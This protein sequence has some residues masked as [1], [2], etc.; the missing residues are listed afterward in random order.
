MKTFK[1]EGLKYKISDDITDEQVTLEVSEDTDVNKVDKKSQ[2]YKDFTEL[3]GNG[4]EQ[5]GKDVKDEFIKSLNYI[6]S[7]DTKVS[8][9]LDDKLKMEE[10]TS[11]IEAEPVSSTPQYGDDMVENMWTAV[12]SDDK[13]FVKN[14]YNKQLI[15]PGTRYSGLGQTQSLIMGALRNNNFEMAD[16]LKSFGETILKSEVDEY[17]DI[18]TKRTYED[19]TTKSALDEDV[20]ADTTDLDEAFYEKICRA[21]VNTMNLEWVTT[22][23]ENNNSV[24][25][26]YF[27]D[28]ETA[29]Q[30]DFGNK[31]TPENFKDVAYDGYSQDEIDNLVSTLTGESEWY[32]YDTWE[33]F[34]EDYIKDE[35]AYDI[36][37]IGLY[38]PGGYDFYVSKEDLEKLGF[39]LSEFL[40][41]DLNSPDVS[42]DDWVGSKAFW[43]DVFDNYG[44][45]SWTDVNNR[46]TKSDL[47]N[48][49]Q[50]YIQNPKDSY[51]MEYANLTERSTKRAERKMC[52]N[53]LKCEGLTG[54]EKAIAGI[55]GIEDNLNKLT[56]DLMAI[57]YVTKVEYDLYGYYD[58][59]KAPI[60]LVSFE[61]NDVEDDE[62]S[63]KN[64]ISAKKKLKQQILDVMKNNG[65]NVELDEFEDNDTYFYIVAYT[66]NWDKSVKTESPMILPTKQQ[67]YDELCAV[68][69]DYE[70]GPHPSASKLYDMLIKIQNNWEQVITAEE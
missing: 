43:V 46:L 2:D 32:E 23:P 50:E 57:K 24:V 65:V 8:C 47:Q 9:E 30:W 15:K 13:N 54:N 56:A 14:A 12:C 37:D 5:D 60:T 25:H 7:D 33:D 31:V 45:D 17:R 4:M 29:Q 55:F 53:T 63:A 58:G 34:Y 39:D 52:R 40:E 69:T 66:T 38:G 36:T 67:I 6:P 20:E 42:Y 61:I 68:L 48:L 62:Y 49:Y 35:I 3:Y 70:T 59:I 19:E 28:D 44:C 22:N 26:G 41:E 10:S 16:L 51:E 1:R 18:M 21:Y 27:P 64:R 11:I